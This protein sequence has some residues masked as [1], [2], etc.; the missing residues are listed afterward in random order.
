MFSSREFYFVF[1]E[2]SPEQ[3][4]WYHLFTQK[5]YRH[6]MVFMQC[7]RDVIQIDPQPHG[8]DVKSFFNILDDNQVVT[9]EEV[10]CSY[11]KAGFNVVKW[12]NKH[13]GGQCVYSV[14]TMIPSC[15]SVCKMLTG[16]TA[17]FLVYTPKSLH[18]WLLKNEGEQ[19]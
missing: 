7:G 10:A 17:G 16:C 3:K 2:T 13:F 18:K 12:S 14:G 19:I 5:G 1:C 11:K 6:V 8:G 9:A 4:K 15:V